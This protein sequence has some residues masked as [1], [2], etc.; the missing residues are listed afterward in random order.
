[1]N[2]LKTVC[3]SGTKAFMLKKKPYQKYFAW[4]A[5]KSFQWITA[6]QELTLFK[7]WNDFINFWMHKNFHFPGKYQAFYAACL[8][9]LFHHMVQFSYGKT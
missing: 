2:K 9:K 4:K 1:M 7:S 5:L 8:L 6:C 3:D